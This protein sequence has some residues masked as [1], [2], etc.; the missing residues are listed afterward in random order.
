[1][2]QDFFESGG[3][4]LL[5]MQLVSRLRAVF[6]VQ[7]PLQTIFADPTIARLAGRIEGLLG[8]AKKDARL[9]VREPGDGERTALSFA[10]RRLWL[11]DQ[12]LPSGSVYNVPRVVRLVGALDVEALRRAFDEL[13]RRHEALRT[14]FEVHDGEPVQVI[15]P[16]LSLALEPEDLSA[17][18]PAQREA[19]AA[20]PR[21]ARGAGFVRPGAR[22]AH[23]SA[24]AAADAERALAAAEP[25][26]HRHRRLVDG[27]VV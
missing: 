22:A 15:E 26:P 20:A 19:E 21:T 5:A 25:A 13:L 23:P 11:L 24:A 10:Q 7:I 18:A 27:S 16:Q 2:H 17:L 3:H 9:S 12:L 8:Q 4:S 1:M 14:R 6:D